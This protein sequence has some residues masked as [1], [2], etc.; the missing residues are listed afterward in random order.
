MKW[1]AL[2][3]TGRLIIWVLQI[4]G[5]TRPIFEKHPLLLELRE[6]DFCLGCWIFMGLSWA[7]GANILEPVYVPGLCEFVTG[8]TIS[9]ATHLCRL[10]W[11]YKFGVF[12]ID[13]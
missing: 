7:L 5:L 13:D 1:I 6:C 3:I 12:E 8:V 11:T 2:V 10:G 4:S 9:F